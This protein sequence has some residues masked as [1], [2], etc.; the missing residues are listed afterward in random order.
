VNRRIV[1]VAIGRNEGTRLGP[2]LA[3]LMGQG[4]VVVYVDS[5]STDGSPDVARRAGAV[6]RELDPGT[7]FTAARARNEGLAQALA[8]I[9]DAE[10]VQFV[11]GDCEMH[12]EWLAVAVD[13]LRSSPRVA[14][15]CGRVRERNPQASVYNRLCELEWDGPPGDVP[16]CGGNALYRVDAFRDANGFLPTLIGGEEPELCL[17]LRRSGWRILRSGAEMVVHDADMTRFG[18]WWR[19]AFRAGWGYGEGFSMHGRSPERYRVRE[20]SSILLWGLLVPVA[21]VAAAWPTWGGSLV[22]AAAGYAAL[23]LRIFRRT[24]RLGVLPRDARLL[25]FFTVLAK[26][27]QAL[28]LVQFAVFRARGRQRSVIDWRVAR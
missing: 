24:T 14:A 16:S 28:G 25:S 12:A 7:P 8:L 1:I 17:R 15:V 22:L 23:G 10:Y 26:F 4:A 2:C 3:S 13:V 19:R 21:A 18:Q 9:P 20:N 27:P 5:G 6:V 11:D